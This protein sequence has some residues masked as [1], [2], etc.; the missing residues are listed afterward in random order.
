MNT[1]FSAPPSVPVSPGETGTGEVRRVL[2]TTHAEGGDVWPSTLELGR[3]LGERGVEVTLAC[4]G[5]P[6]GP[7]QWAE[8]REV[9]GLS[10]EQ[11]SWGREGPGAVWEEVE[12]AGRWLLELEARLRPDAVHLNEPCHGALPWA[13]RPLVVGHACPLARWEA[14]TGEPA[15]ERD[16][17]YRWEM[18]RGLRAAGHVVTASS[19]MLGA[20]ERHYGPLPPASVIPPGR[21]PGDFAP[22]P[23]REP[24]VLAVGELWDEAAN[25]GVL[26]TVASRLDWP[27]WVAGGQTHP[28]GGEVRARHLRSLGPLGP[29]E[30]AGYLGRASLYVAPA[31]HEPSG[32]RVLE[33][34][35]AGCALVLGD[36]PSLREVWEDAAVFV[37]PEDP[38]M[39]ARALRR[40]VTEPALCGRMATLARTRAL[41]LSPERLAES[42]LGVYATLA[43]PSGSAAPRV[44]QRAGDLTG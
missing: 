30:L 41:T 21:R 9:P 34:A 2:M 25:L 23:V 28:E 38:D 43:H 19:A 39:L 44:S 35:L 31:L 18:T 11:S 1:R 33:A 12:A 10:V 15:V 5:A 16:L 37:S 20:L 8:V 4:L 42:Y 3:A 6:L 26:E 27:V 24:F 17:R 29:R 32:L 7:A 13:R 36:I 40:L 22:G 14:V